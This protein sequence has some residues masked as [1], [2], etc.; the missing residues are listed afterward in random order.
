MRNSSAEEIDAFGET[1]A[2]N[3]EKGVRQLEALFHPSGLRGE[4]R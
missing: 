2:E 3:Q 4:V 1:A